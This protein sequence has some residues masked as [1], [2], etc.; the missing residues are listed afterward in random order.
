[1]QT[2]TPTLDQGTEPLPWYRHAWPWLLMFGPAAVI[3]AGAYTI[4]LAI[5]HPDAMVVDDYYK[6]GK[7]INQDLRRDRA[8]AELGLHAGLRY[9]PA[10]EKLAG[11]IGGKVAVPEEVLRIRLIHSTQPVKDIQLLTRVDRDG[12]FSASLPAMERAH[13]QILIENERG[14][15]RLHS[16][17]SWPKQQA[18]EIKAG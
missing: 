3:L 12:R 15:W 10:A 9:D 14:T 11:E 2:M 16:E 1:M 7:A 6:Q 5:S 13:W 18:V 4:W 8:A 17:W